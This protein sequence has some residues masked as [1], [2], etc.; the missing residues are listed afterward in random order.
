MGV[1]CLYILSLLYALWCNGQLLALAAEIDFQ[2]DVRP[3][4]AEHCYD[5]HG[6]DPK[7]RQGGLRLD[8]RDSAV[9]ILPSGN[10]AII[11][12][13]PQVSALLS[14]VRAANPEQ[15]MPPDSAFQL[16]PAEITLLE[17]WIK[18]GARY[19]GHWAF[20]APK[21]P[22]VPTGGDRSWIQNPIDAFVLRRL[23]EQSL[24][25][26]PRADR[27]Q[28]LRRLSLLMRGLPPAQ[29]E[30]EWGARD[31]ESLSQSIERWLA[32]PHFGERM[33][34]DWL[35]AAR[36]ADT[37]GHAAD[38]PRTMWLF[39]D[40]VIAAINQD[41]PFDQF[42]VEQLAGDMFAEPSVNQLIATGFHRNSMQALGNN[43]RKEEFRVKGIVDRLE[44][45]GRVWL[46]LSLACA[47]CHDHKYDPISTREYYQVFAIFNNVPHLGE[48]FKVHGPQIKVQ[49]SQAQWARETVEK[50]LSDLARQREDLIAQVAFQSRFK[51]ALARR[52]RDGVQPKQTAHVGVAPLGTV[53][54]RGIL[55][56]AEL[57]AAAHRF[58]GKPLYPTLSDRPKL[59]GPLTISVWIKTDHA[60]GDLVSRYDWK[61]NQRSFV[62][63]IGG[64]GDKDASPGQLYA[65]FSQQATTFSGITVYGSRQVDDGQ[66]HHVAVSYHPGKSVTLFVDGHRDEKIRTSGEVPA[67]LA[68]CDRPVVIGAGYDDSRAANAFHFHGMLT[69][70]RIDDVAYKTMSEV[71]FAPTRATF[72]K[73]WVEGS[74]EG[75][76][77]RTRDRA[78]R[79]RL[80]QIRQPVTAQIMR[81]LPQPRPTYVHIRGDYQ[82]RGDRVQPGIPAFLNRDGAERVTNRLEFARWLVSGKHPLTAR[83][84]V[85]RIWQHH[86]G[87][88]LVRTADD[89]GVRGAAAT[90]P[91]LLD[92]LA[93]EFVEAGW[94]VKHIHRLILHSATFQ[95]ASRV[96]VGKRDRDVANRWLGRYPRR[97]VS[98][99]VVRDTLLA[100]S[101]LLERRVG[102]RSVYPYQ[103]DGVGEFRDDTAG[104]WHEDAAPDCFRR[105]LYVFWQRTA[106]YPSM[107]VFD[108]PSRERCTVRRSTTN[109]PLHALALLNDPVAVEMAKAFAQRVLKQSPDDDRKTRVETMFQLALNRSPTVS[110]AERCA[111]FIDQT[112]VLG[113]QEQRAWFHLAG[114]VLNL[115][116]TIS[117]E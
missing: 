16:S 4:L 60:V 43:P 113:Q 23:Q 30:V 39:R 102:G 107:T 40:W 96:T 88:G 14:R 63:G 87:V 21:R 111:A 76:K 59:R 53:A 13:R 7:R 75:E 31:D 32:S 94:S 35:D 15:R 64:A 25:P 29:E 110:E 41:M 85:N 18:A 10:R 108:A 73:E 47:E 56:T 106:P 48:K 69:N 84:A 90:H 12:V 50:E 115:D 99:E 52:Q 20:T 19:D 36:Y 72:I 89:F 34:Q 46:G 83:V 80:R 2:R 79:E 58:T 104:K 1:S 49:L 65:R 42:S 112:R 91:A 17:R 71:G 8:M 51:A 70:L 26:N 78:L 82:A 38:R 3:I 6:A 92:W 27:R 5:C 105:G 109:T 97:R 95:Q 116:E 66:W 74:P 61:A 55:K 22:R 33:A 98:A 114:A 37:A 24:E 86:F 62:F 44:T 117:I 11:P 68:D 45:T 9:G 67:S 93:V 81:E 77:F 54:S 103:P 28:L 100:I 101:G 57:E